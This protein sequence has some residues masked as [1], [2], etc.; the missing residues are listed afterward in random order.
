V[1]GLYRQHTLF[2]F[3]AAAIAVPVSRIKRLMRPWEDVGAPTREPNETLGEIRRASAE[4]LPGSIVKRRLFFRY[5]LEWKK[6]NA[7]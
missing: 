2:D 3:A 6:P 7:N 4:T 1:I 5:S